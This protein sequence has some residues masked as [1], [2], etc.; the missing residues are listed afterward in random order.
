MAQQLRA[1]GEQVELLAL[2]DARTTI[3]SAADVESNR[4]ALLET[5]GQSLGLSP[6]QLAVFDDDF[7][8][9]GPDEQLARVLD[10][11]RT[12]NLVP[13]DVDLPRFRR[14]LDVFAANLRATHNYVPRAY[15]GRLTIFRA[16]DSLGLPSGEPDLGWAGLAAEG[17]VSREVAGNH[18]SMMREPNVQ[19][20]AR[21]LRLCLDDADVLK[22]TRESESALLASGRDDGIGG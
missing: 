16:A 4:V 18:Y 12:G 19:E 3:P 22:Q 1:Q 14:K 11:A 15:P 6:D 7:W 17:A 21:Q 20:L 13:A 5:F 9:S 10:R 2:M 8:K